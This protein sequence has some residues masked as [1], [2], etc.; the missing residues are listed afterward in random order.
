[1]KFLTNP[2]KLAKIF[3]QTRRDFLKSSATTATVGLVGGSMAGKEVKAFA[4]EPYPLD[5]NLETVATSCAH[6]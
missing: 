4:Y 6:N 5:D 3:T 1:M 2:A